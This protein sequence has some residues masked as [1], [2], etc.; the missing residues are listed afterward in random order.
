M[1][2][3]VIII[4]TELLTGKRTD[5]HL[6]TVI[7][8]LAK[9]GFD[10]G[11]CLYL[12]DDPDH[13]ADTLRRTMETNDL[14]LSFGGIGATPDDHTRAA[15]ALA[16]QQPLTRHPELAAIIEGRF[17]DDAYPQRI[18]MADLPK[19]CHLIPNPVNQIAGFSVEHHHFVPGF[20][21]MAWPMIE[22]V[23]DTYYLKAGYQQVATE[24]LLTV[25]NTGEGVLVDILEQFVQRFPDVALSCLP[26]MDGDY[27]ETELGVRGR[28]DEVVTAHHWLRQ[29]L[30]KRNFGWELR[31]SS[32]SQLPADADGGNGKIAR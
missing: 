2:T 1:N 9:R 18:R 16:C 20:P 29:A 22:W 5:R 12:G 10:L 25:P 27:R 8:I 24:L 31:A 17:G 23:L 26:H 4:G 30:D 32:P 6:P 13:L 11:W 3:G 7:D 28:G 15:A 14:V 21:Q 19:D